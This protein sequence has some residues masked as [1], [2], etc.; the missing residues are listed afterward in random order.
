MYL[1]WLNKGFWAELFQDLQ[2]NQKM[3][4]KI[5]E[6]TNYICEATIYTPWAFL[7][8]KSL[9]RIPYT[10]QDDIFIFNV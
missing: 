4:L 7:W 9:F 2:K 10:I 3:L 6:A 8:Y 5:C 1:K